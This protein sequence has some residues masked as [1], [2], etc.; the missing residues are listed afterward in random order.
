MGSV[1]DGRNWDQETNPY[2]G[3]FLGEVTGLMGPPRPR[4]EW[5][6]STLVGRPQSPSYPPKL[7]GPSAGEA[8]VPQP[9]RDQAATLMRNAMLTGA[10]VPD[11]PGFTLP[12]RLW[13][14][15]WLHRNKPS[16]NEINQFIKGKLGGNDAKRRQQA[17]ELVKEIQG[18]SQ[19]P[20]SGNASI[21]AAGLRNDFT[22]RVNDLFSDD[23]PVDDMQYDELQHRLFNQRAAKSTYAPLW[24]Q[25]KTVAK[26]GAVGMA[27]GSVDITSK[28]HSGELISPTLAPVINEVRAREVAHYA[29]FPL[30]VHKLTLD[31]QMEL[32][33][34]LVDLPELVERRAR[35]EREAAQRQARD[36]ATQTHLSPTM[37]KVAWG[38]NRL[39]S[40]GWPKVAEHVVDKVSPESLAVDRVKERLPLP[41]SVKSHVEMPKPD[42]MAW[43]DKLTQ[44][45]HV[46]SVGDVTKLRRHLRYCLQQ[47]IHK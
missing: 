5:S 15:D 21:R 46:D 28:M 10:P 12:Q 33:R 22:N 29:R 19:R 44:F 18:P 34:D 7:E 17:W 40:Q 23:A 25:L 6:A 47:G 9:Y 24:D 4:P 37:E 39:G 32:S 1:C 27:Q 3:D 14:E 41:D 30:E 2:T 43:A 36:Y 20:A 38:L 8:P 13:L 35:V 42:V 11:S 16:L 26:I 45:S 31:K